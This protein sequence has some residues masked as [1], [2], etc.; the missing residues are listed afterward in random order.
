MS[1]HKLS[2]LSN[3]KIPDYD[4]YIYIEIPKVKHW[5]ELLFASNTG[6][7]ETFENVFSSVLNE[8]I[9][10][11]KCKY[12]KV[13]DDLT[14]PDREKI[15][16]WLK[17]N[18][19]GKDTS[20]EYECPKC[21]KKTKIVFDL[22][23]MREIQ[24][25]KKVKDTSIIYNDVEYKL[26]V[27]RRENF[28][29]FSKI[30]DTY[31][32]EVFDKIKDLLFIDEIEDIEK[33]IESLK[34]GNSELIKDQ[35]LKNGSVKTVDSKNIDLTIID[36]LKNSGIFNNIDIDELLKNGKIDDKLKK[37]IDSFQ[38]I[39]NK[40]VAIDNAN[41]ISDEHMKK[42]ETELVDIDMKIKNNLEKI[43]KILLSYKLFDIADRLYQ[44][45]KEIKTYL[46]LTFD[47]YIEYIISLCLC[48]CD[49][50]S[51]NNLIEFVMD[52]DMTSINIMQ[53]FLTEN[54]HGFENLITYTCSNIDCK[55]QFKSTL[56][57]TPSFF[58]NV[59]NGGIGN[60]E[61]IAMQEIS[62]LFSM[63]FN[64]NKIDIDNMELYEYDYNVEKLIEFFKEKNRNKK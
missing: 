21:S 49:I 50:E 53:N 39:E 8:L 10:F 32:L 51:I 43:R 15:M 56:Y 47:D 31:R 36:K 3:G 33:K 63:F 7:V 55:Y 2:L 64:Y 17:I 54:K 26:I 20:I 11:S 44:D 60:S 46:D 40:K 19:K 9:D 5:R 27:P 59:K 24:L 29:K 52:L 30:I 1:Y 41:K 4:T 18:A 14:L 57:I 58:F 35:L 61:L 34:I 62:R 42:Y 25:T 16:Y 12:L 28:L 37:I 22:T 13:A 23:K 6:N 45:Y 48:I 38:T